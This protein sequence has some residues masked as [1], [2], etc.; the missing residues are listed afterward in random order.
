MR[1]ARRGYELGAPMLAAWLKVTGR[2]RVKGKSHAAEHPREGEDPAEPGRKSID[3]GRHCARPPRSSWSARHAGHRDHDR[4]Q[5]AADPL[6][7]RSR[8]HGLRPARATGNIAAAGRAAVPKKNPAEAG[9]KF[10]DKRAQRVLELVPYANNA[11][12]PEAVPPDQQKNREHDP[13]KACP[14]LDPGWIPVSGKRSCSTNK[15]ERDD[16]SKK[17]HLADALTG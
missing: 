6:A 11:D 4:G 17:S 7:S 10:W 12:P 5:Q 13:E 16:D 9:L 1:A 8:P 15:L 3:R 14:G 2:S